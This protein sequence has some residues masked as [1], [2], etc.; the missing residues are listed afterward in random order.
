MG[1]LIFGNISFSVIKQ[2]QDR[3]GRV[4]Y[5][6]SFLP[7]GRQARPEAL[8]QMVQGKVSG[9]RGSIRQTAQIPYPAITKKEM[10][11]SFFGTFIIFLLIFYNNI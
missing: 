4:R 3:N 8:N 5:F 1:D 6:R 11:T 9:L 7:T 2:L 10:L